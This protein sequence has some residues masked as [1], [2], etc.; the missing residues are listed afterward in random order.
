[1]QDAGTE[2]GVRDVATV[3]PGGQGGALLGEGERNQLL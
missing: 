2:D 1:M 3:K